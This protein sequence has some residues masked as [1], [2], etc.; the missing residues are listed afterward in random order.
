WIHE[1]GHAASAYTLGCKEDWWSTHMTPYLYRSFGGDIDYV[2]LAGQGLLSVAIVDGF[3]V[4]ANIAIMVVAIVAARAT[5]QW[6]W[7]YAWLLGFAAMNHI[8]A[9]TYL[10]FNIFAPRSDMIA[11]LAALPFHPWWLGGVSTVTFALLV[12]VIFPPLIDTLGE[13]L[14]RA[15]IA[16]F[17]FLG[18]L[19]VTFSMLSGRADLTEG[20]APAITSGSQACRSIPCHFRV[21]VRV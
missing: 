18:V 3:G 20:A 9:M 6:T 1:V 17:V 21:S 15:L 5:R 16:G 7:V 2:C 11:V 14:D 4:A 19:I 10:T 12:P 8:E 13:R